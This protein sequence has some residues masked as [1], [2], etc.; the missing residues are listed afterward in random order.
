MCGSGGAAVH[1]N[2]TGEEHSGVRQWDERDRGWIGRRHDGLTVVKSIVCCF[3]MERG[4]RGG[5]WM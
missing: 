4:Y 3:G 2:D 1:T 5:E